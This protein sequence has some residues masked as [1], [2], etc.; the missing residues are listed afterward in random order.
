MPLVRVAEWKQHYHYCPLQKMGNNTNSNDQNE[1]SVLTKYRKSKWR[2]SKC[3]GAIN[4]W[5][6]LSHSL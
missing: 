4:K 2:S 3:G 1:T 6:D 5:Q